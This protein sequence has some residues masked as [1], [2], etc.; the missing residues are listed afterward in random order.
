MRMGSMR[1]TLAAILLLFPAAPAQAQHVAAPAN[2]PPPSTAQFIAR[3]A[4]DAAQ[5]EAVAAAP[6][7][8]P[9]QAALPDPVAKPRESSFDPNSI[10]YP[11]GHPTLGTID[12]NSAANPYGPYGS[13]RSLG[14]LVP[15]PAWRVAAPG[16]AR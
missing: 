16:R 4:S 6:Y 15:V 13:N 3:A 5:A 8:Q 1:L 9:P 10:H 11:Y 2:H 14:G 7:G 12:P